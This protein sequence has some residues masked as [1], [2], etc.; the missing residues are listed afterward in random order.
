[1]RMILFSAK[2]IPSNYAQNEN[3]SVGKYLELLY[4]MVLHQLNNVI[5]V[6][7][8]QDICKKMNTVS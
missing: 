7:V 6:C 2:E 1:M 5:V 3:M 8:H 4:Q